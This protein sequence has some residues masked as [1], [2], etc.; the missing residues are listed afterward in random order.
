MSW[1]AQRSQENL[2]AATKLLSFQLNNGAA[3]R[4]WYCL[5]HA[6]WHAMEIDQKQPIHYQ[7]RR[8]D[9]W[10]HETFTGAVMKDISRVKRL[11]WEP[12]R[13]D[14]LL[15]QMLAMRVDADYRNVTVPAEKL[16]ARHAEVS[17]FVSGVTS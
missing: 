3:N 11:G 15:K 1:L 12:K 6:C 9:R 8:P 16:R 10:K 17:A 13:I 14:R 5:Y 4:L 7:P 2:Q